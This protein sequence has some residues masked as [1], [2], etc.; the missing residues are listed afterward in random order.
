MPAGPGSRG[1]S[2]WCSPSTGEWSTSTPPPPSRRPWPSDLLASPDIDLIL[3]SHAHVV[4][5]IGRVNGKV[6]VY[7][8][9]NHLSNQNSIWGPK[10]Y[11]TE[12]GLMVQV[13]VTE[14]PDGRFAATRW[15]TPRPG[16]RWTPTGCCRWPGRGPPGE[17][18]A[19]LLA[20][21]WERT[22][23]TSPCWAPRGWTAT[24]AAWPALCCA[25]AGWPTWWGL[26][27]PTCSSAPPATTSIT[28][29]GGDDTIHGSRRRRP[30]LRR[31]R[32]RHPLGRR[33]LRRT[34]RRGR[35]RHPL[36]RPRARHPLGRGRGQDTLWGETD[37]DTLYGGD[38]DD[39]LWG[40]EGDDLLVAG[41]GADRLWGGLGADTLVASSPT[42]TLSPDRYDRCRIGA[43]VDSLPID[44]KGARE[45]T[46]APHRSRATGR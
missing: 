28:G 13:T 12:D 3:G 15:S 25:G 10:Y 45:Q 32:R 14:Q 16:W 5:P 2:S 29:R 4:Q 41:S 34:P 37:P 11:S 9:G 21:S 1:P 27:A 36:R 7:G 31:R 8:M 23:A 30:R 38:G 24:P 19:A 40:H 43:L 39:T 17:G 46:L 6:V 26:P 18:D 44:A 22:M 20:A 42:D 33:R 35:R